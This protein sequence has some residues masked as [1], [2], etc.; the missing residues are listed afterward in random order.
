MIG[1]STYK[2]KSTYLTKNGIKKQDYDKINEP[3]KKNINNSPYNSNMTK[4]YY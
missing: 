1:G 4:T 3:I 2:A